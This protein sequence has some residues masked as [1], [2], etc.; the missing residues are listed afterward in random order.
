MDVDNYKSFLQGN[1][2]NSFFFKDTTPGEIE[3]ITM[4]LKNKSSYGADEVIT[5]PV[6]N[7]MTLI[8]KPLSSARQ[9]PYSSSSGLV[10]L[11][12]GLVKMHSH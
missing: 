9:K 7:V 10:K 3:S 2:I 4:K 1:F 6:K 12:G 5:G 11:H 8:S